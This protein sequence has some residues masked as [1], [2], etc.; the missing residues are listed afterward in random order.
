MMPDD[1][2]IRRRRARFPPSS[3]SA[4]SIPATHVKLSGNRN[5]DFAWSG[6]AAG[7]AI[8]G[9]RLPRSRRALARRR[10]EPGRAHRA[11]VAAARRFLPLG[12]DRPAAGHAA[13]RARRVLGRRHA[14]AASPDRTR[15]AAR[16]RASTTTRAGSPATRTWPATTSATT[17][18]ARRGTTRSR[19]TTCSRSTRSTWRDSR[20]RR[21]RRRRRAKGD[22]R[23]RARAGCGHRPLHA[24]SFRQPVTAVAGSSRRGATNHTVRKQNRHERAD[25]LILEPQCGQPRLSREAHR[26]LPRTTSTSSD[27][28]MTPAITV[29][30][31]AARSTR[32]VGG[33][34]SGIGAGFPPG[35]TATVRR[36]DVAPTWTDR[37]GGWAGLGAAEWGRGRAACRAVGVRAGG[38][39]GVVTIG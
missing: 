24:Q 16:G 21:L 37:A 11:G 1:H 9:A 14:R 7:D 27:P 28:P 3:R 30:V 4:R 12:A 34:G 39:L 6:A 5:P 23:P 35:T 29:S 8:A 38:D 2:R 18:R 10:R 17:D 13:D 20:S 32:N 36:S 26:Q 25:R 15:R 22:G 31:R 33:G 19:I